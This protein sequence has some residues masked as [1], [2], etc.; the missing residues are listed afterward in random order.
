MQILLWDSYSNK[1]L[2]PWYK[3][4]YIVGMLKLGMHEHGVVLTN[5]IETSC[6]KRFSTF[7]VYIYLTAVFELKAP[8]TELYFERKTYFS[9]LW[10][11]STFLKASGLVFLNTGGP[12]TSSWGHPP[13]AI[14]S[15]QSDIFQIKTSE[16]FQKSNWS[17]WNTNNNDK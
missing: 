1:E 16:L 4:N 15:N 17:V 3:P 11:W 10:T 6:V 14:T 2:L 8:K 9:N 7:M 5:N 13:V 12:G